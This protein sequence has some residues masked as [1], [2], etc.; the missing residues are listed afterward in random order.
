[1]LPESRGVRARGVLLGL[2]CGD[3]LGTTLEFQPLAAPPFPLLAQGPHCEIT[4]GGPFRVRP[5]QV[6][7]DTQMACCLAAS[8]KEMNGFRPAD[9]ARRYVEWMSH[10]FDIGNLTRDTLS[11]IARGVSLGEA[12]RRAWVHSGRK[13]APNG[14]LMRT[15]PIAVALSQDPEG[16]RLASLTESAITHYDPRCRLACAAFNAALGAALSANEQPAPA[17]I[18]KTAREELDKAAGVLLNLVPQE[19]PEI[20]AARIALQED[21]A[22]SGADDP[23]LYGPE[24]HI[25]HG[26][27]FVRVAF[28]LAFWELLHAPSF[29]AGVIDAVNRGGDADTNGAITG[30]LLGGVYGEPAIPAAWRQPVLDAL[31]DEPPGPFRD[32][33]HPRRLL[34]LASI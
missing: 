5:G 14:S 15:A 18:V 32:V 25:H 12:A 3:A 29:E 28:R 33:Y 34:D 10:A 24:L 7:D 20:E 23:E 17:A 16:R 19:G 1:M 2:A 27:G 30:A 21:L 26:P 13:T 4:G 6:T 8:L 11:M 9:V 22:R 31:R